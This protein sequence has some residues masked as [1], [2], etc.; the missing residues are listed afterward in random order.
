MAKETVLFKVADQ[1]S[2]QEVASLLHELADRIAVQ[3]VVLKKGQQR[4]KLKFPEMV[5][6]KLRVEKKPGKKRSKKKLEIEIDWFSR[7]QQEGS[8]SLG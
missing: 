8:F 7:Q 3:K 5:G 1:K 4:V 6:I 2:I